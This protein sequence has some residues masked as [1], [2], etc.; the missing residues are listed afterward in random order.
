MSLEAMDATTNIYSSIFS[1]YIETLL[2]EEFQVV[3]YSWYISSA[4]NTGKKK[5]I[6]MKIKLK[7][8]MVI[9]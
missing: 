6:F 1:K 2:K 8:L 5:R 4:I 9:V 7:K 3:L